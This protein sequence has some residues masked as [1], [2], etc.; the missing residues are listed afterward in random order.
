MSVRAVAATILVLVAAACRSASTHAKPSIGVG[1]GACIAMIRFD[2]RT[3]YGNSVRRPL[4]I[5][6][7]IGRGTVPACQDTSGGPKRHATHVQLASVAGIRISVA[8]VRIDNLAAI[9]VRR[10]V[11]AGYRSEQRFF[12]CLARAR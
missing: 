11:C 9:Y 3:Y 5:G 4:R 10:G 7:R 12:A 8:V 6:R 2:A 1:G